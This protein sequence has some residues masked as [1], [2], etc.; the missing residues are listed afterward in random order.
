[1]RSV[2]KIKT[3]TEI[4]EGQS[5]IPQHELDKEAKLAEAPLKGRTQANK[6]RGVSIE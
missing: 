4:V 1:M 3:K 6:V 2:K 5:K